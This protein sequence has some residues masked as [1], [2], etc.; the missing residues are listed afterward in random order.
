MSKTV[1]MSLNSKNYREFCQLIIENKF[2]IPFCKNTFP[3]KIYAKELLK[4]SAINELIQQLDSLRYQESWSLDAIKI[5][6]AT[7]VKT[8]LA[9]SLKSELQDIQTKIE[10]LDSRFIIKARQDF[11]WCKIEMLYEDDKQFWD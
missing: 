2:E 11:N 8:T 10:E 5:L 4:N 9:L 7:Q 1:Y 3:Q 6:P